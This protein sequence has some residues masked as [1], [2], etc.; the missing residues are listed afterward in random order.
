MSHHGGRRPGAG[1]KP[2][3]DAKRA[4]RIVVAFTPDEL[5]ELEDARHGKPLATHVHDL[6]IEAA[7]RVP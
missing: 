3:G 2:M 1:R 5:A 6:A 4:V 7:R